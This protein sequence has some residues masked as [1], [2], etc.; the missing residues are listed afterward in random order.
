MQPPPCTPVKSSLLA[1]SSAT[2]PMLEICDFGSLIKMG[3]DLRDSL[4]K[5]LHFTIVHDLCYIK[6][7]SLNDLQQRQQL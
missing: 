6:T 1:S 7:S 4:G 2:S 3:E 5:P